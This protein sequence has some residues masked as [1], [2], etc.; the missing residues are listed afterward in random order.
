VWKVTTARS[1]AAA[2]PKVDPA[3]PP[4]TMVV[5][6]GLKS[7][8]A[9]LGWAVKSAYLVPIVQLNPSVVAQRDICWGI[10]A[11]LAL[12]AEVPRGS[13]RSIERWRGL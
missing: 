6:L 13:E 4:G 1:C 7:V 10:V 11:L 9:Q 8:D 12:A 5:A 2:P 3:A